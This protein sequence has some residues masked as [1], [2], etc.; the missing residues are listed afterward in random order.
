L[1]V[2][3]E[4]RV[5]KISEAQAT[6]KIEGMVEEYLSIFDTNEI[7]ASQKE[8]GM[9]KHNGKFLLHLLNQTFSKKA[10]IVAKM[11]KQVFPKLIETGGEVY[12]NFKFF[13]AF[14]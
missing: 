5:S 10:A 9:S 1:T 2:V 14:I 6:K 8:L 3:C 11:A 4:S 12:F 7:V 13:L